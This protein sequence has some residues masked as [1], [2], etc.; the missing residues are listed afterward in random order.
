MCGPLGRGG[1][2]DVWAIREWNCQGISGANMEGHHCMC[3]AINGTCGPVEEECH[4]KCRAIMTYVGPSC[5]C[6]AI[7]GDSHGV[8]GVII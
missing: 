6:K 8:G 7:R 3:G 1:S 2:H 4:V 5:R